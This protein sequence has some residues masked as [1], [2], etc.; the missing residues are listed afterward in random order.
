M[1]PD[2][3]R[4]EIEFGSRVESIPKGATL[5]SCEHADCKAHPVG[6]CDARAT[7]TVIAFGHRAHLCESCAAFAD[8]KAVR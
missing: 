8:A 4:E 5:C 3:S 6:S 1:S 7:R 2:Y